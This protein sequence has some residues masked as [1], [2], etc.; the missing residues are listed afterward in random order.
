MKP[1]CSCELTALGWLQP[2]QALEDRL[3]A[4]KAL[5]GLVRPPRGTTQCNGHDGHG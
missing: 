5:R 1:S 3:G 2:G 4:I